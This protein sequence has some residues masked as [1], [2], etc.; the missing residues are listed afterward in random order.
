MGANIPKLGRYPSG[1]AFRLTPRVDN[2]NHGIERARCGSKF[3]PHNPERK[4]A[5]T[6]RGAL[7]CMHFNSM[8]VTVVA[9]PT[10]YQPDAPGQ[11]VSLV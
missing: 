2:L 10:P 11:V 6:S 8:S 7:E 4:R 3:L 9:D 1:K 5:F